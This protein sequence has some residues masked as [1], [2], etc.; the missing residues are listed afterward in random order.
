MVCKEMAATKEGKTGLPEDLEVFPKLM[1]AFGLGPERPNL[2]PVYVEYRASLPQDNSGYE[3]LYSA[4]MERRM[5]Q[6]PWQGCILDTFGTVDKV[7][8][9]R[10]V[11]PTCR[12]SVG[13]CEYF[14]TA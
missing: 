13:S 5:S 11:V 14:R 10:T 3:R 12:K 2:L 8:A 6:A 9:K 4:Y 7:L 1:G